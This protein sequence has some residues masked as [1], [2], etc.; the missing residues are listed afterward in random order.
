M[1]PT[2]VWLV[3]LRGQRRLELDGDADL[4]AELLAALGTDAAMPERTQVDL[5]LQDANRRK[6]L[7]DA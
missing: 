2:R 6:G 5:Q 1:K 7:C 4:L 3:V